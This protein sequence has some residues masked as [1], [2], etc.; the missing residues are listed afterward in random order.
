MRQDWT[1]SNFESRNYGIAQ[2]TDLSQFGELLKLVSMPV[3]LAAVFVA[4]SW[5]QSQI[6]SMGYESQKLHA[7]EET[8]RREEKALVLEEATLKDPARIDELARVLGFE[9]VRANQVLPARY[10]EPETAGTL[11]GLS[12]PQAPQTDLALATS[13]STPIVK[14][15]GAAN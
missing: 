3:L 15:L 5:G 10:P 2:R 4:R 1:T 6:V 8:L 14:K 12:S 11:A 9:R 7:L 13:D